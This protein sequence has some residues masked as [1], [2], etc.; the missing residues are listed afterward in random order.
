MAAKTS[1]TERTLRVATDLFD[2]HLREIG[3]LDLKA[4]SQFV[5]EKTGFKVTFVTKPGADVWALPEGT[6]KDKGKAKRG[7][8]KQDVC[9]LFQQQLPLLS[10]E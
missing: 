10:P 4:C 3:F 5:E 1:F 7:L 9:F 6:R 8:V 2:G